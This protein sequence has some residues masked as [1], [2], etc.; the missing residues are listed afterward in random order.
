MSIIIKQKYRKWW[1]SLTWN[2]LTF[3]ESVNLSNIL[4]LKKLS[5]F[6]FKFD[7]RILWFGA[8]AVFCEGKVFFL[9][10]VYIKHVLQVCAVNNGF[11]AWRRHFC[12]LLSIKKWFFYMFWFLMGLFWN[13]E[14]SFVYSKEDVLLFLLSGHSQDT[15]KSVCSV[16][17]VRTV[18]R[19]GKNNSYLF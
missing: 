17:S 16:I 19:V 15:F 6:F 5:S 9:F 11:A 14:T 7:E 10:R 12:I 8:E 18:K 4:V 13:V 1:L 3:G 2:L